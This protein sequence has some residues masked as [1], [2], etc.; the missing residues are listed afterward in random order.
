MDI[1]QNISRPSIDL[2]FGSDT[3]TRLSPP[4][5]SF[6]HIG[7][8]TEPVVTTGNCHIQPTCTI[9][10][11]PPLDYLLIGGPTPDY[12]GNV[13]S[14]IRDFIMQ[15]SNEVK[16][17]LTTCTGGLVLGAT[18]LLDG[19]DA[20]ANHILIPDVSKAI[21]PKVNWKRDTHWVV[22]R[23]QAQGQGAGLT[24]W[25]AAGAGAGMDMVAHWVKEE[26]ENGQALLDCATSLLEWA[27]RDINGRF[28]RSV[29]GRGETVENGAV[30]KL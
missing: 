18:G 7:Q 11:C 27:P 16:A 20:T 25:T 21:A 3:S 9:N 2:I 22:A 26:F 13:P 1:L 30:V 24:F 14:P 29:N 8:T 4:N 6:H 5:I 17:I 28:M 12:A 23:Q 15:R 19:L 10:N